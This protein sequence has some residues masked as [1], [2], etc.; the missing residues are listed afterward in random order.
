MSRESLLE[1]YGSKVFSD[2]VMKQRLDPDTYNSLKKT[3]D[4]GSELDVKTARAVA[5]AMMDWAVENGATHYTHWFQPLTGVTAEKHESFIAPSDDGSATLEFSVNALIKGETDASS[6]PSGGLRDTF[7]ARG[8]TAWD[9]TSP[10][11]IKDET[12]YIP[13]AFCSFNGDALDKKT[14]LLRSMEVL[15]R[16]G[17]RVLRAMGNTHSKKVIATCGPEQEYFLVDRSLYE[18][19][20]DLKLCG[21]TLLG[22]RASKG[23]E[24]DDHYYGRLKIRVNQFMRDLDKELWKLGI[25][26]KTRHNE[27]APAQH[28]LAPVYATANIACDH[29]QLIMTLMRQEAKKHGFAC[30]LHEKPYAGV[31]GS[32]KHNNWSISTDDGEILL[33]PGDTPKDNKRFLL[34]LSA[35]LRA[36]DEY[37][38]LLRYSIAVPGNDLRLGGNEAPPAIISVFLGDELGAVVDSLVKDVPLKTEKGHKIEIGVSS[39]PDLPK[40]NTDRNRTSPFAFTGNKFEFRMCGAS[41]SVADSSTFINTIVADVLREFA[42]ILEKSENIDEDIDRLI[43]DTLKEHYRIIFN[44]NGYT[45][46]WIKEATRRGLPNITCA[47]DAIEAIADKKNIEMLSRTGVLSERECRARYEIGLEMYSKTIRIEAATMLDMVRQQIIP[48]VMDYCG[49]VAESA[50]SV[51]KTGCDSTVFKA[52]VA[53]LSKLC[54]D[55]SDSCGVLEGL[56]SIAFNETNSKKKARLYHERVCTEMEHLRSICD[57]MEKNTD[58]KAWPIPTYY[59]L[60]YRI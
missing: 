20:M 29:N 53:K 45:D 40:D 55:A 47:V 49:K 3:I 36:V 48:A 17:I 30:L 23:Q 6:F 13:T 14:P 18:Q 42:D 56:M 9:C 44:G 60:L 58:S 34:F 32:G 15:S 16:E 19:R 38:D 27:V 11:F 10:A 35:I 1:N 33:D 22:S 8:Y 51:E 57:A 12:L 41:A 46:E 5:S 7:E 28:E 31:N 54:T 50:E 4:D 25:P 43:K 37:A 24:M 52:S 21:R 59:E 2:R 26:S 39:L